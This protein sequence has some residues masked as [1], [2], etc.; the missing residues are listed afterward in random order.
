MGKPL[1]RGMLYG[2]LLIAG[3]TLGMQMAEP[4]PQANGWSA[5]GG[6]PAGSGTIQSGAAGGSQGTWSPTPGYN[7]NVQAPGYGYGYPGAN[8]GGYSG[9]VGTGA[10]PA[11]GALPGSGGT[12]S[13]VPTPG[14]AQGAPQG[15]GAL[16][17]PAD[18][19]LPAPEAPA[20]DRFADKA[21]HLLQQVSRKSIHWFA[22]WFGPSPE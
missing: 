4:E 10:G 2:V 14:G 3:V 8:G 11:T 9:Y 22:S 15:N 1:K 13:V 17:T 20:V 21:A 6:I 18:L 7:V 5:N 16:Q 19:L 12:G